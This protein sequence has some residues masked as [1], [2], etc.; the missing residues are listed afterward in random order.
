MNVFKHKKLIILFIVA[1]FVAFGWT[2]LSQEQKM[3]QKELELIE[4]QERQADLLEAL[5]VLNEEVAAL[6]SADTK[7]SLARK[8]LNM[9]MPGEII[10]IITYDEDAYDY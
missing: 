4:Q 5:R 7:V 10:Y 3:K 8:K 1:L 2:Y 9:I 6:E